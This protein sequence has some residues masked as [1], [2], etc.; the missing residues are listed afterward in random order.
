MSIVLS[1]S[2]CGPGIQAT[3][4]LDN[5]ISATGP[6]WPPGHFP[7]GRI[8]PVSVAAGLVAASACEKCAL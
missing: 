1:A 4:F 5:G 6:L 3:T 8:L 7:V 2:I